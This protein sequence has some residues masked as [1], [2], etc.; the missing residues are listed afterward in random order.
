MNSDLTLSHIWEPDTWI[1]ILP[2]HGMNKLLDCFNIKVNI[3]SITG[4]M[5]S[6]ISTWQVVHHSI[7]SKN[8]LI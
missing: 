3:K 7:P 4:I 1:I 8:E 6:I 5:I 2:I